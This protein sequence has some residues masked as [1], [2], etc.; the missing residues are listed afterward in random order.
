MTQPPLNH[1]TTLQQALLD[2]VQKY[3][4]HFSRSGLAK[5]LVGAKSWQGREYPEYGRFSKYRR[6]DVGY[7]VDILL[8][9][10]YLR[11]DGRNHLAPV[12]SSSGA[13]EAR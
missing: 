7:Q 2:V 11:L 3:P 4:G 1:L 8:Q 13:G 6:K 12:S 5:M 10:S 9:Q